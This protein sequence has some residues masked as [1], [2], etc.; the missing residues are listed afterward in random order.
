MTTPSANP[1]AQPVSSEHAPV[2]WERK[3]KTI[4]A[5]LKDYDATYKMFS[6]KDVER[7]FD[8]SRTGKVNVVHE[9]VDR[10]AASQRKNKVAL[11]YTD[12][13]GRDERYTFGDLKAQTSRFAHVLRQLGVKKGDRVGTFLP[14]TPELYIVILGINRLG[15][16]PVPL[17]EAFM[18]QAVQDRLGDSEAVVC[19]TSP[20]LKARIPRAKL[21]ALKQLVLVGAG[22][23]SL[24]SDEISYEAAVAKAPDRFDQTG[25]GG[26]RHA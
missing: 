5:N 11:H 18:E 23:G 14:R 24:A 26:V 25:L 20:A 19:V 15:A 4:D 16:I 13:A 21:P 2:E 22:P 3:P 1:S 12:Y 10:H 8:W 9:A 6:W 7:E 17:F